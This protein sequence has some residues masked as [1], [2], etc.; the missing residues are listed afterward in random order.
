MTQ[1]RDATFVFGLAVAGRAVASSLRKRGIDVVLGDD[2]LTDEHRSFAQSIGAQ[3]VNIAQDGELQRVMS[4]VG[5]LSPAPGVPENHAVI[6]SAHDHGVSIQSEIEISYRIEQLR[7][8]GSRPM[9]A[10]T[11]TDGKTTTTRLVN[12]ILRTAGLRS[13]AVGNTEVPLIES[14][15]TDAQAFAIE[16]SSFRLEHTEQFRTQASAWLNI[17]P[18]HLDWHSSYQKYFDAKAK[19]WANCLPTDVA[20]APVDDVNILAVARASAA[21]MVTFGATEGDYRVVGDELC[22]PLGSITSISRM[23]RSLPHDITNALAAAAVCIESGLADADHVAH[24]LEHFENAPHRI[25]FVAEVDGV[26]WFNDSKATSP[27]AV[28]VALRAFDSIV[29]IAGGKNKGLDLSQMACEP[30][31]MRAVVAIGASADDIARA[32]KGVCTVVQAESMSAAVAHAS[33]LSRTGDVVVL[34]PGCTSY[35]WYSNY[36]ERGDDF[37]KCVRELSGNHR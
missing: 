3:V 8:D 20:V 2:S 26:R 16:C 22:G 9:V 7:S 10:V 4:S 23:K 35:D 6:R 36:G 17:A 27:H 19:M 31:R 32:F 15:A 11:G 13:E 12:A 34:S 25:Q 37:M 5:V 29:L 18:D 21:R 28:S 30:H 24:A 33:E 14:L 1:S